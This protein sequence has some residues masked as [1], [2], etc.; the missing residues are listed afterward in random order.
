MAKV[1]FEFNGAITLVQC[2]IEDKMNDIC[3][4]FKSKIILDNNPILFLYGGSQV[5]M[6]L[7]FKELANELDLNRKEMNIL[8]N[9]IKDT[10]IVNNKNNLKKSEDIICP[11]CKENCRMTIKDYK[12]K[13]YE[14][15]NEHQINNILLSQFNQTQFINESNILCNYCKKSKIESINNLFY[16]CTNCQ[17]GMCLGCKQKHDKKH[18]IIDYNMKNYFCNIHND[19]LIS[20]CKDCKTNLCMVCE[21]EHKTHNIILYRNI[22]P[23]EAQIKQQIEEFRKKVD[24]FKKI[25]QNII[26]KLVKVIENIDILFKIN[27][28]IID[29]YKLQNRNYTILQN[30]NGIQNNIKLCDIDEIINNNNVNEQFKKIINIYNKMMNKDDDKDNKNATDINN[31]EIDN[32][33][34][35]NNNIN[36]ENINDEGNDGIDNNNNNL[37]NEIKIVYKVNKND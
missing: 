9:E 10:Q 25:V 3:A 7:S 5:N 36:N 1:I 4:K 11:E 20:Y 33:N 30:L 15:K 18:K 16:I 35:F 24:E 19:S 29:N 32:S 34:E 14:C 8:V 26:T 27:F 22:F 23:N 17:K 31:Q 12:I 28:D 6:N 13:L 21:I 37:V 2:N